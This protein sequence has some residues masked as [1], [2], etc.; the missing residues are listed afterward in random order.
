MSETLGHPDRI[1]QRD[2]RGVSPVIATILLVAITV[3]L[4]AVLYVMVAGLFNPHTTTADF[5][6]VNTGKTGNGLDWELTFASVPTDVNQ[7]ITF[8]TLTGANGTTI[9]TA[10]TLTELEALTNG[11]QYVP[12]KWAVVNLAP[13]DSVLISIATYPRG[14]GFS[15]STPGNVLAAGTLT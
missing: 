12:A 8:L 4:A 2:P 7:N 10:K 6:G 13:G 14:T 11:V 1:L 3:V 5:L 15:F 9:F